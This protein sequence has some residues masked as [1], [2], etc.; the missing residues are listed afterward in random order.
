M[1]KVEAMSVLKDLFVAPDF[2]NSKVTVTFTRPRDLKSGSWKILGGRKLIAKGRLPGKGGKVRLEVAMPGFTP[3]TVDAPYRY[4]LVLELKVGRELLEMDVPFGMYKFHTE[5]TTLYMNNAPLCVRGVI[6][7]R[8]AHDH[9]NLLGLDE[10]EFYAKFIRQA[11]SLGFNFI[12]FHS[13]VP[14]DAYFRAADRL[15]QVPGVRHPAPHGDGRNRPGPRDPDDLGEQDLA[16]DR[17]RGGRNLRLHRDHPRGLSIGMHGSTPSWANRCS[18]GE[19]WY[20]GGAG[21]R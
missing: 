11:K 14:S 1:T 15:G 12:R 8:E 21:Y 13:R 4:K 10:E 20:Q 6:R 19:G 2:D 9:D 7:G 5:G 18:V 3:W 17:V 16:L